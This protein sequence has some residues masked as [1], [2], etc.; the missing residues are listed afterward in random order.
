MRAPESKIFI[1]Y[2]RRDG[3]FAEALKQGL[4][5]AGYAVLID[6]EGI[7]H[8]EDWQARL[9][10]LI[11]ESDTVVFVLSP[12]SVASEICGWEIESGRLLSKRVVPVLWRAV[13]FGDAPAGVSA[14]NA[15]PFDGENAV[16]GLQKLV[17]ALESDLDWLREHTRIGE[18]AAEWERSGRSDAFLLRGGA[19][20]SAQAWRDAQPP[21]APPPTQTQRAYLQA[22]EEEESR[23]LSDERR[24]ADELL[25]ARDLAESERD[26]A[27][28]ARAN[29]T[30]A[31]RRVVRATLAGMTVAVLLFTAAVYAGWTAYQNGLAFERAAQSAEAN[32]ARAQAAATSARTEAARADA[33][34]RAAIAQRDATLRL[35]SRL[36]A[37]S[38]S[39][40]LSAGDGAQAMAL[41]R[42]ALPADLEAPERPFAPEA[43]QVLYDAWFDL[44]EVAA[45]RDA[46]NPVTRAIAGPNG[47]LLSVSERGQTA[48]LWSAE[49]ARLAEIRHA[50]PA[51]DG[52]APL[53]AGFL[54]DGRILTWGDSD[55]PATRV[56]DP[57]GA[58]IR[59]LDETVVVAF[60]PNGRLARAVWSEA[61]GFD[62]TRLR[63]G[64]VSGAEGPLIELDEDYVNAFF[65]GEERVLVWKRL[66]PPWDAPRRAL[67]LRDARTGA[68]L[69]G[70]EIASGGIKQL[71][72][73]DDRHVLIILQ[74]VEA[75]IV[76]DVATG[77]EVAR[78]APPQGQV[79]DAARLADGRYVTW[80]GDAGDEITLQVWTGDGDF[81]FAL[82]HGHRW[83]VRGAKLTPDDRLVTWSQDGTARVFDAETGA[84]LFALD[85]NDDDRV[86][87]SWVLGVG[88][89]GDDQIVTWSID[90]SIRLWDPETGA[91][92][93]VIS[94]HEGDIGDVALLAGDRAA[95]W[96]REDGTL[97]FWRLSRGPQGS[98]FRGF[99]RLDLRIFGS[100]V[101]AD[102]RVVSYGADGK[103]WL[104]D[105]NFERETVGFD[106]G[107][108]AVTDVA[109]AT[110]GGLAAFGPAGDAYDPP[111][112]GRLMAADGAPGPWL[113]GGIDGAVI[114]AR[115]TPDGRLLSWNSDKTLRFWDGETGRRLGIVLA[116]DSVSGVDLS[117]DGRF[118]GFRAS[119]AAWLWRA[120]GAERRELADADVIGAR[121][122]DDG[123]IA[124]W[125]RRWA[126]VYEADGT[127][128]FE[129]D[130]DG[131]YAN[132]TVDGDG[133]SLL[134][135]QGEAR[136]FGPDGARRATLTMPAGN[137]S[138]ATFLADGRVATFGDRRAVSRIWT[139]DGA[140]ERNLDGLRRNIR[141][142][143]SAPDGR[144]L[145]WTN[146]VPGNF[147]P[148][149]WDG[150]PGGGRVA[151]SDHEG[152]VSGGAF[153][154]SGDVLIW[155]ELGGQG[156]DHL[157]RVW[158]GD[159]AGMVARVEKTIE[160]LAPLTFAERCR[161]FL[162]P[163]PACAAAGAAVE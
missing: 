26:A 150:D 7:A 13:D 41:A 73:L 84:E 8:G 100:E 34:A 29:E 142:A 161:F 105:P 6:R 33:S 30:K 36:L 126:R 159:A 99:D 57:S 144:V 160:R 74:Q 18:R 15:V 65:L 9:R 117:P 46:A 51:D 93:T 66:L 85:H 152:Y 79:D 114:G 96:S 134:W 97:R 81:A 63:L 54:A 64:D 42:R 22:S 70:Y 123:R 113:E 130:F 92:I 82:D 115:F 139:R 108:W 109:L 61:G 107:V 129:T 32:A 11:A 124:V 125:A 24:R 77:E 80:G 121:F 98:V 136:L 163:E 27:E 38:A 2:S 153:L 128:A 1:S 112:R 119:G 50:S 43:L 127:L 39:E 145:V 16:T 45:I 87:D 110:D 90:A 69:G 151:L 28:K 111:Y 53:Y 17:A 10:G 67:E 138:S 86:V 83:R 72:V 25:A 78:L 122:L 23:L 149:L 104:W 3:D 91:P 56:W 14:L 55:A 132:A 148:T 31:A 12:D 118:L 158:P 141:S 89:T 143:A 155:A 4:E 120:D 21:T 147:A 94:G 140:L 68:M 5:A 48:A 40:A 157:P 95:S 52:Y 59:D 106:P 154:P 47:A 71:R 58:P 116:S 133:W 60:S 35:E 103:A 37:R 75:A 76:W 162:E 20:K 131:A 49:G 19:L 62:R 156:L 137:I 102:G 101:A 44:R 146:L 135:R 88:F